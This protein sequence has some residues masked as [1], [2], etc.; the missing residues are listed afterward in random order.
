MPEIRGSDEVF[1]GSV[2]DTNADAHA[3]PQSR[4]RSGAVLVECGRGG[5][6]EHTRCERERS[7]AHGSSKLLARKNWSA[8]RCS[9]P[10]PDGL[11][12]PTYARGWGWPRKG[13]QSAALRRKALAGLSMPA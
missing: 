6:K 11:W 5:R 3:L 2:R 12:D 9:A 10:T 13:G 4:G 1:V 7:K 8:C